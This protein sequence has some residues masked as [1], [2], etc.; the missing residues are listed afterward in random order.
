MLRK[1]IKKLKFGLAF[2]GGVLLLGSVANAQDQDGVRI[3]QRPVSDYFLS[4]KYQLES[5]AINLTSKFSAEYRVS[6]QKDGTFDAKKTRLIGSSGDAK[7]VEEVGVGIVAMGDSGYF[8]YL[9]NLNLE[10]AVIGVAGDGDNF[11]ARVTAD[12]GRAEK[13]KTMASGLDR[14]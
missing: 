1:A 3:N 2:I 8:G 6:I 13:A 12:A 14:L 5:R 4:L 10:N 9:A 7:L 11:T